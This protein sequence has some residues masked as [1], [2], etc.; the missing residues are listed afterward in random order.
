M[1]LTSPKVRNNR[2]LQ[3]APP[4]EAARAAALFD[5]V[6][7]P[8]AR[9]ARLWD[10]V[11]RITPEAKASALSPLLRDLDAAKTP[12]SVAGIVLGYRLLDRYKS[13][14]DSAIHQV[15]TWQRSISDPGRLLEVTETTL[16]SLDLIQRLAPLIGQRLS[17]S[18]GKDEAPAA[19]NAMR[20]VATVN[21]QI[22]P[23]GDATTFRCDALRLIKQR[24]WLIFDDFMRTFVLTN[25]W[26][27]SNEVARDYPPTRVQQ[28]HAGRS[29]KRSGPPKASEAESYI[30][31]NLGATFFDPTTGHLLH[32]NGQTSAGP[33]SMRKVVVPTSTSV[34][35][36]GTASDE[37]YFESVETKTSGGA[38]IY[39]RIKA[40]TLVSLGCH[41]CPSSTDLGWWLAD[42]LDANRLTELLVEYGF[43][44]PSLR[45]VIR[46]R[47]VEAPADRRQPEAKIPNK[48]PVAH[49]SERERI[50]GQ[51]GGHLVVLP[52]AKGRIGVVYVDPNLS[53]NPANRYKVVVRPLSPP[54]S[55]HAKWK[56]GPRQ[57]I[58]LEA[59]GRLVTGRRVG[60]VGPLAPKALSRSAI[61]L[62]PARI[63]DIATQ[64]AAVKGMVASIGR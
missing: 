18:F 23:S 31:N 32:L 2:T 16:D 50:M 35:K 4:P 20:A 60:S 57:P 5:A 58:D 1:L 8:S 38:D 10:S 55:K 7:S 42:Q 59:F 30:R 27:V 6:F 54:I 61:S 47:D 15:S 11:I 19:G 22:M 28:D 3:R 52:D 41:P 46:Q 21:T 25:R 17:D 49:R 63:N 37:I 29:S 9:G 12:E 64:T 14:V 53:L 34:I 48:A 43:H 51:F 33:T 26:V 24:Q 39:K 44:E 36:V 56:W 40:K 45:P 62:T 13:D